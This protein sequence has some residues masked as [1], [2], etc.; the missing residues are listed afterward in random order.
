MLIGTNQDGFFTY[1]ERRYKVGNARIKLSQITGLT[2]D[3]GVA[4]VGY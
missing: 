4:R 2:R 1:K 3:E